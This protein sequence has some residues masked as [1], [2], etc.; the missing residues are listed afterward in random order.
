MMGGWG[1]WSGA[2]GGGGYGGGYGGGG[3]GGGGGGGGR[4]CGVKEGL[5]KGTKDKM[6]MARFVAHAS[7]TDVTKVAGGQTF[8]KSW[9]VRNDS[10][11]TWP[12]TCSLVPVS[13]NCEDLS[14]PPEAPVVGDVAPGEEAT[15]SVDLV[16]PLQPGM[17]EGFWRVRDSELRKF[18]Q[19]LW[20][21]VKV[22][23]QGEEMD[24]AV[25]KLSLEDGN[26][27]N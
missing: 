18:G 15:V 22:V 7:G 5:G 2:Y 8:K 17:Y 19:R 24:A 3:F 20:A 13:Q 26:K 11:T 10:T 25:E 9:L 21:K 6:A 4:A 1:A 14:S 27:D 12:E 23:G 16:A